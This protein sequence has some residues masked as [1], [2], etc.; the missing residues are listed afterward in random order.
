MLLGGT[1]PTRLSHLQSSTRCVAGTVHLSP[2]TSSQMQEGSF[3]SFQWSHGSCHT[4]TAGSFQLLPQMSTWTLDSQDHMPTR[5]VAQAAPT[6][7]IRQAPP[8][9]MEA[10]PHHPPPPQ[11]KKKNPSQKP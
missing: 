2:T 10:P 9:P 1:T 6:P 4:F 3:M 7:W 11:Q 5:V 8:N